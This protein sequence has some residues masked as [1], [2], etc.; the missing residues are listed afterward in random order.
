MRE[1]KH[2]YFRDNWLLFLGQRFFEIV[3][4]TI[5]EGLRLYMFNPYI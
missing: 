5:E 4:A 3:A 2:P 1:R